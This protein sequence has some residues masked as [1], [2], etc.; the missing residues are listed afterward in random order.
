M[1]GRMLLLS[2]IFPDGAVGTLTRDRRVE[3]TPEMFCRP[4][5]VRSTQP[6]TNLG[7]CGST[8]G[9]WVTWYLPG[10]RDAQLLTRVLGRV[11]HGS[12]GRLEAA[13]SGRRSRLRI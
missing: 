3:E 8:V 4:D 13:S 10:G 6:R 9:K 11:R 1:P 5:A 7:R 12:A 2:Q